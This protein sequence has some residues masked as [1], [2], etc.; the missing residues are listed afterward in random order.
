MRIEE[1][2]G[3]EKF[4]LK[5]IKNFIALGTVFRRKFF[6]HQIL[7]FYTPP[8]YNTIWEVIHGRFEEKSLLGGG[9][10]L[11]GH[12]PKKGGKMGKIIIIVSESQFN[13]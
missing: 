6:F 11:R 12:P 7:I 13:F 5:W 8:S 1:N 9:D 4:A 10:P 2:T 3:R